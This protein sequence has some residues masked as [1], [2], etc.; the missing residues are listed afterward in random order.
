MKKGIISTGY[1]PTNVSVIPNSCDLELFDVNDKVKR[2]RDF[3]QRHNIPNDSLL[4]VY[5]G[6]FGKI[7]GVDYLVDLA[8]A[9]QDC[10][11]IRFLAI[12]D[13]A[14]VRKRL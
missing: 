10:S 2:S 8:E 3:R 13:G 9:L 12:G 5:A 4:I 6:T 14:G 7:N 1:N 11:S